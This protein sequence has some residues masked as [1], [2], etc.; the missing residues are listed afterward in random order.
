[1]F[2]K[3]KKKKI[4]PVVVRFFFPNLYNFSLYVT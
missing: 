2:S 3:K 1:M 4:F